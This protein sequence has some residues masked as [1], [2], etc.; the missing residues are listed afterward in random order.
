[1]HLSLGIDESSFHLLRDYI[2]GFFQGDAKAF[3]ES[4][5]PQLLSNLSQFLYFCDSLPSVV[6]V[7][8]C[9]RN[10]EAAV[11]A[12]KILLTVSFMEDTPIV[13]EED[14]IRIQPRKRKPK[15]QKHTAKKSKALILDPRPFEI[16]G[17]QAPSSQTEADNLAI[18]LLNILRG[19]LNVCS[20]A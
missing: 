13:E 4:V 12:L 5:T 17:F 11:T 18:E 20:I 3:V 1:M 6:Q 9:Y 19:I 10:T 14:G 16:L 2:C 15:Y 8:H 7:G